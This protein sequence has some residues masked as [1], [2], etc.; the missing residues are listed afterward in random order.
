MGKHTLALVVRCPAHGLAGLP[1]ICEATRPPSAVRTVRL[2]RYSA[3]GVSR[4][5]SIFQQERIG[6]AAMHAT[7]LTH[8]ETVSIREESEPPAAHVADVAIR[9]S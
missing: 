4:L 5:A 9:M 1:A 3:S 6:W 8:I 7:R 2:L